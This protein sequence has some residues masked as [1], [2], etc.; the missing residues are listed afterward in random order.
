[1]ATVPA[2]VG[3]VTT[4]G[5]PADAAV[6]T[7]KGPRAVAFTGGAYAYVLRLGCE[8]ERGGKQA[9]AK[10]SLPIDASGVRQSLGVGLFVE[11]LLENFDIVVAFLGGVGL[12]SLLRPLQ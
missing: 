9:V 1:M 7:E 4:L 5:L 3:A 8:N 2:V 6:A 12:T 10:E 11:V